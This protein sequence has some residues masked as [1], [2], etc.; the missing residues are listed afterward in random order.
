MSLGDFG[1]ISLNKRN[2]NLFSSLSSCR[3]RSSQTDSHDFF[4]CSYCHTVINILMNPRVQSVYP[5]Y[6]NICSNWLLDPERTLHTK[7]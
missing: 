2:F 1:V 3:N 6:I 7:M 5:Q 4:F